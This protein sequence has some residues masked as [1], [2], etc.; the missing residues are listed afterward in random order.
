ML[1]LY[2]T[3]MRISSIYQYKYNIDFCS[4]QQRTLGQYDMPRSHTKFIAAQYKGHQASLY[5]LGGLLVIN[6]DSVV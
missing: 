5:K 1:L 6:D 2:K 3:R 4:G